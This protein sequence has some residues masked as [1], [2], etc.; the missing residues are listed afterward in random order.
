MAILAKISWFLS[1]W[2]KQK[3]I[4]KSIL[5]KNNKYLDF[6]LIYEAKDHLLNQ[7]RSSMNDC[8]KFIGFQ[9]LTHY[10]G[11]LQIK[12]LEKKEI[13]QIDNQEVTQFL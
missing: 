6:D 9:G 1:S 4:I 10:P 7:N 12:I 3:T 2:A 8:L 5:N 13:N 11:Q